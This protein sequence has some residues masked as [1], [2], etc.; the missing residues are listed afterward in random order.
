MP[1][2]IRSIGGGVFSGCVGIPACD[3][4]FVV[5]GWAAAA[6]RGALRFKCKFFFPQYFQAFYF[7]AALFYTVD[8]F[9][10]YLRK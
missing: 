6:V 2:F 8:L 3:T 5:K 1:A 10:V 7:F 9:L 4:G